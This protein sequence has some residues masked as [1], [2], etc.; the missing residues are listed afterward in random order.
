MLDKE[1][2]S[3]RVRKELAAALDRFAEE[4]RILLSRRLRLRLEAGLLSEKEKK[5]FSKE[6]EAID[7]MIRLKEAAEIR[8]EESSG[9]LLIVSVSG[10][11]PD[12]D[13]FAGYPLKY[14]EEFPLS[15]TLP[16]L[17]E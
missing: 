17:L 15:L 7:E 1:L 9:L 10:F 6:L 12:C 14:L 11:A 13:P 8:E 4:K 5:M 2:E 16:E 3:D